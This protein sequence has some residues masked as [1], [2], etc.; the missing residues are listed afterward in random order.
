MS[1]K[2]N[3]PEEQVRAKEGGTEKITP[4]NLEPIDLAVRSVR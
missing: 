1:S 3:Q 2:R 4:N